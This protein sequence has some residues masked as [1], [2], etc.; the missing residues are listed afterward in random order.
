[1]LC[2]PGSLVTVCGGAD[3]W[4]VDG[5]FRVLTT[6]NGPH[7]CIVLAL[8]SEWPSYYVVLYEGHVGFINSCWMSPINR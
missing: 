7:A 6:L 3:L 4:H 8:S 2:E 5:R 1:M